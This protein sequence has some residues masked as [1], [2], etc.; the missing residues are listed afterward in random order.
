M[1]ERLNIKKFSLINIF[2]LSN[3]H[4]IANS[5]DAETGDPIYQPGAYDGG[6]A[7]D[8]IAVLERF[9]PIIFSDNPPIC[10]IASAVAAIVNGI[11]WLT[12][13][14]HRVKAYK[15]A[16]DKNL[17]DAAIAR[18]YSIGDVKSEILD[19]GIPSGV[20]IADIGDTVKKS[21]R[22]TE[23]KESAVIQTNVTA[24]IGY[25]TNKYALFQ[26]QTMAGPMSQPGDSGSL[27][28][29]NANEGVGLLFA[30]SDQVTLFSPIQYVLDALNVQLVTDQ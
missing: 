13:S 27:V 23:L 5:N 25:G 3:N 17:C 4:V 7:E 10:S 24:N 16:D 14:S 20:A 11:A 1:S 21:G 19:I 29:N 22:T 12:R 2:I 8:K 15:M 18:P 26:Q 9:E 30:G 6:G 28:L